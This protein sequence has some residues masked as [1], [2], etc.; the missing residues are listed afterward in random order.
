VDNLKQAKKDAVAAAQT[1][2]G[3]TKNIN[4]R[5]SEKDL[6]KIKVLAAQKG[7]PYQTLISSLLHQ[8]SSKRGETAF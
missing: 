8:F 6:Q 5:L 1:T 4:I 2:L 3:K 7:L